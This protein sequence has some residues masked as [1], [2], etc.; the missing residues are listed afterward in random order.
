MK[1]IKPLFLASLLFFSFDLFAQQS[2]SAATIKEIELAEAK[3]FQNVNYT[4]ANDYFKT[5][6]VDD[7]FTIN[8]DGVSADKQQSLLDTVRLKMFEMGKV[9]VLDKKIRVYDNVGITNGRGQVFVNDAFVLEFL[10]TAI[11][12]KRNGKWMYAGWQGTI[13]KDS[14]KMGQ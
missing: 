4:H 2:A 1:V 12:V 7:F 6:V 3:M 9:K 10:Y 13:S 8:S 14:P 11:F 5:D